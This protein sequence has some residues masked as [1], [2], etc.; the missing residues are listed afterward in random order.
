MKSILFLVETMQWEQFR[1][2]YRKNK[3]LFLNF[4]LHFSNLDKIFNIFQKNMT[5]IGYVFSK[6]RTPKHVLR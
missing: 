5:L 3:K 4:S 2:I 6:L 1:W